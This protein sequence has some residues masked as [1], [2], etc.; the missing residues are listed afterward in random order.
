M[1]L[2]VNDTVE[3]NV[4][5]KEL[6]IKAKSIVTYFKTSNLATDKLREVQTEMKFLLLTVKQD[7][8]TRWTS[9]VIIM[10]NRLLEIRTPLCIAKSHLP[11]SPDT[12]DAT[13]CQISSECVGLGVL[14]H[15]ETITRLSSWLY[16]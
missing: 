16:H 12:L 14:E 8:S 1:N 5:F 7:V 13:E 9:T 6:I 4:T 2:C 11:K 10:L 3:D 15:M